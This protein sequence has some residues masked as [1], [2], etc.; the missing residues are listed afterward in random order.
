MSVRHLRVLFCKD[1]KRLR[2]EK[3]CK[4]K[5]HFIMRRLGRINFN[6]Q[7]VVNKITTNLKIT[8]FS[9]KLIS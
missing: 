9:Y 4:Y 6:Y 3:K 5:L 2:K 1:A 8:T 7:L